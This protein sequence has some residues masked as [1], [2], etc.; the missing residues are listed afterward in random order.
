MPTEI[1]L[2]RHLDDEPHAPSTVD[3]QRAIATGRRKRRNRRTGYA[4]VAA[5][6]TLAVA[7]V[8]V[9]SGFPQRGPS[10]TVAAKP[11]ASAKP[12]PAVTAAY[13]I[14]GAAGWTAPAATA[15]TSC[16]IE[17][18]PVPDGV[19]MALISG[20]DPTG[21]YLVGRSYPKGAYQAVIWH[22]GSAQKVN[23]PGDLEENLD[24]VNSAGAAV[25]WSYVGGSEQNTGPV[26]YVY[27]NGKVSKLTGVERGSAYAINDA[28]AIVGQDDKQQ[29]AV[30][31]PSATAKAITLPVPPGTAQSHA[32]DID[33]DGTTVGDLDLKVPYVWF[34]D[35]THRA[36]TLPSKNGKKAVGARAFTIRNGWVTGVADAD[37]AARV[38]GKG[39][40]MW[41]VR[42][43]LRTG[44]VEIVTDFAD[45]AENA[46]AQGWQIGVDKKGRAAL[47]TGAGTVVLPDLAKHAPDTLSNIP[48]TI[49]DD[50]RIIGGQSDD[51]GDT[52][53]AVI[54]R[55]E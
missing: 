45:R 49:S 4:G 39:A 43:N 37:N 19:S 8:A 12:S 35:G 52:I 31:W 23:L 40:E 42:W 55:C 30:L 32:R 11:S 5:L 22:N 15:P 20:A 33:E 2:L 29:T 14:P 13:T 21:S 48:N 53:H 51:M 36:L 9:V 25:G 24:D 1:D 16:R 28:G 50:G 17:R 26:P 6:T 18:L 54:W 47:A 7:G 3:I 44:A 38:G 46:N 41:G 34:A 27:Q 10:R